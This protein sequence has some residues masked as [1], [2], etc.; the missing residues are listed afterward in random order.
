MGYFSNGEEG[1]HYEAQYC[2]CCI[3]GQHPEFGPC[4]C[5]INELHARYN[6]DQ[7]KPMQPW[8][9]V[10]KILTRLIPRDDNVIY[11][12]QCSTFYELPGGE[13]R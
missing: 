1:N 6:Y 12:E 7:F 9:E 2:E 4:A 11:N 10:N 8:V 3:H 13:E 5:P